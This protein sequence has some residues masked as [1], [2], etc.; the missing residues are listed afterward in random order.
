MSIYLKNLVI[1]SKNV[2]AF[3]T[4]STNVSKLLASKS[5]TKTKVSKTEKEKIKKLLNFYVDN[6]LPDANLESQ[7][8]SLK[9]E[10]KTKVNFLKSLYSLYIF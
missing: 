9:L 4:F 3:R 5:E 10:L 6:E 2:K 8:K 1:T 7:L